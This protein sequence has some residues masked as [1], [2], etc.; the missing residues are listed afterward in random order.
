MN[1][2]RVA[3]IFFAGM[4]AFFGLSILLGSWYTVPEGYRGVITRNGAVIGVAEP[5]LGFKLPLID[6]VTDMSVQTEKLVWERLAAYSRDIQQSE[7]YVTL[8]YRIDPTAVAAIYSQFGVNYAEKVI[9]PL[10]PKK[11]KEVFGQYSAAD[12]VAKREQ[13]GKDLEA[14]IIEGVEVPW[15]I[16]E[17]VQIENI[18]FSDTYEQAIEAA[19]QAEANVKRERQELERIKVS[20]QQQVAQAEAA[21]TA[22]RM[23]ADA[24]AYAIRAQ[25]EA[26]AAAIAARGKALRDNPDLVRLI[27]AERWDGKMPTTM[28]PNGALPFV[29]VQ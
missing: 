23:E 6:S 8:T 7:S 10:V 28:V 20:A 16:V 15:L 11:A 24:L 14:S 25:G 17:S 26:E 3:G 13:F 5:G 4:T 27:A 21:A 22:K 18:D 2:G 9:W 29:N 19:A 12:I 1:I